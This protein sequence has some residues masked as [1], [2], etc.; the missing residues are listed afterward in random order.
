MH[1][2]PRDARRTDRAARRPTARAAARV[3]AHGHGGGVLMPLPFL[4]QR[5][6]YYA[7]HFIFM[8]TNYLSWYG[9]VNDGL[10]PIVAQ[11][12]GWSEASMAA[13]LGSFALGYVPVQ[14]P[15]SLIARKIQGC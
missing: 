7:I 15:A 4:P 14:V 13:L 6:Y 9:I 11:S 8:S 3:T 2:P 5:V 1:A 12:S 10:I